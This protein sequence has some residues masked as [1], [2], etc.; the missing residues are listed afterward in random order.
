M[1]PDANEWWGI[2]VCM[3]A[4][5]MDRGP[6]LIFFVFDPGCSVDGVPTLRCYTPPLLEKEFK[7]D[8]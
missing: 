5:L 6:F 4:C 2:C 3:R 7:G 1:Y 8:T